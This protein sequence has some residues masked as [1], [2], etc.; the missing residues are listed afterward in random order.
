[1]NLTKAKVV[2]VNYGPGVLGDVVAAAGPDELEIVK[3]DVQASEEAQS[4]V[5][6]DAD[7]LVVEHTL[8]NNNTW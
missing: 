7:V 1:M 4:E 3:I 5:L 6:K 8:G 2:L